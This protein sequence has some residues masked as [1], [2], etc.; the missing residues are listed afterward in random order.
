MNETNSRLQSR[1]LV[2][3]KFPFS[4]DIQIISA[5]FLNSISL[6]YRISLVLNTFLFVNSVLHNQLSLNGFSC[7]KDC[8]S[9][10][11]WR[12]LVCAIERKCFPIVHP[13]YV[14]EP[15]LSN[16]KEHVAFKHIFE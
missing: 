1:L 8:C 6:F 10:C 4:S 12:C 5:A 14:M 11:E 2:S 16:A 3:L 9:F 15:Y 13:N 7:P